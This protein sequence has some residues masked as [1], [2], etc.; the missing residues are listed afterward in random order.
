MMILT[1]KKMGGGGSKVSVNNVSGAS[2][3]RGARTTLS[4]GATGAKKALLFG[5]NYRGT[6]NELYGCINDVVHL[7]EY[8]SGR[9]FQVETCTDDTQEKPTR[10]IIIAKTLAFLTSLGPTDVGFLWYSGH[11]SI[12]S[13][14]NAWVPLDYSTSGFLMENAFESVIKSVRSGCR[15]FIGSDSCYSGSMFDIRYDVEPNGTIASELARQVAREQRASVPDGIVGL[16]S[17]IPKQDVTVSHTKGLPFEAVV[18]ARAN[19]TNYAL[20][21]TRKI[22]SNAHVVFLSGCRDNQTSADAY[23]ENKSQGAMTWAFL[24][25]CRTTVTEGASLGMLQDLM[26]SALRGRFSQVPQISFGGPLS[27]FTK[28]SIFGL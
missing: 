7:Q 22:I 9:G 24:R 21:D 13:G 6:N 23:M 4:G 26:R 5:L 8:L 20:Y 11:G 3:Y 19:I 25:A 14:K 16:A 12:V 10:S 18:Q 1:N 17:D 28:L 27:P 15:L 2:L